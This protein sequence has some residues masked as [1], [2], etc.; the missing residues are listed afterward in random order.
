MLVDW[1]KRTYASV[2]RSLVKYINE[3][4]V[5][6]WEK[7]EGRK[8]LNGGKCPPLTTLPPTIDVDGLQEPVLGGLEADS[9]T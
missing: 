3:V 7:D 5:E 4:T 2:Q 1:K 8:W 6:L 9:I